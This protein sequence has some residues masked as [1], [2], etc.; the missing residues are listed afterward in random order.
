MTPPVNAATAPAVSPRAAR[1]RPRRASSSGLVVRVAAVLPDRF[2]AGLL[3]VIA[4]PLVAFGAPERDTDYA[5]C[6]FDASGA[7]QPLMAARVPAGG[8]AV[9]SRAACSSR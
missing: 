3:A 9:R 4:M 1:I 8:I 6:V 7:P 2:S 5:V